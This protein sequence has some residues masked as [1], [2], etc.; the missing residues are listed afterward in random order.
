MGLPPDAIW[1]RL[2]D[3][4]DWFAAA[5][6]RPRSA[7]HVVQPFLG[8]ALPAAPAVHCAIV[9]GSWAMVTDRED[10]SER[11]AAWLATLVAQRR[12]VLGVCYGHQLMA[13]ALGGRV[14]DLS[15]G[16]ER[17]LFELQLTAAG[18]AD[19]WLADLPPRFAACLSHRQSVL[20]P[21]PMAQVL[22]G[23]ARDPF[24]LLRYGPQA[25]SMQPH[26]E[27][28]PDIMAACAAGRGN[29]EPALD[30]RAPAEV[31]RR[32]WLPQP[33]ALLRRFVDAADGGGAA[34]VVAG[35]VAAR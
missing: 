23:T 19:P 29:G 5:L 10:W 25:L 20:Q 31:I 16:P 17:G 26:P 12:P 1:R 30:V 8:E 13:H 3:Q 35:G 21:P 18:Q 27:F 14:G 7:L 15:G 2:G 6:R 34:E 28:T 22:G 33:L 11:T 24:Q 32:P 9:T 4:A